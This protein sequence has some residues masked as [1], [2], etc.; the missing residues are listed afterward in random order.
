MEMNELYIA[1]EVEILCFRPVENL[2][3]EFMSGWSF[4]SGQAGGN[5]GELESPG[6]GEDSEDVEEAD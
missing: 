1:P 6:T 4:G 3:N 5:Q 2:A